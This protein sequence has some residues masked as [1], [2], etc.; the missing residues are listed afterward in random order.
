MPKLLSLFEFTINHK[1]VGKN[2]ENLLNLIHQI[3]EMNSQTPGFVSCTQFKKSRFI[4]IIFNSDNDVEI[5]CPE[6][7]T[8]RS[9]SDSIL[10]KLTNNLK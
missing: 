8:L 3:N 7:I 1:P 6:R 4:E 5:K 2:K 10:N 9:L